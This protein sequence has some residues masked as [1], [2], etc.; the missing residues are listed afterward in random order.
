MRFSIFHTFE[1]ISRT[2]HFLDDLDIANDIDLW[3]KVIKISCGL[4]LW[5]WVSYYRNILTLIQYIFVF[6][7]PIIH[8]LL[9]NSYFPKSQ[10]S[11]NL[12]VTFKSKL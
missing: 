8:T 4:N 5:H 1:L 10:I 11:M 7:Y 12:L 9:K 6:L 2:F 3:L